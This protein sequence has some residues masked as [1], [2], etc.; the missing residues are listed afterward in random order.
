MHVIADRLL[1]MTLPASIPPQQRP[2]LP[3]ARTATIALPPP[4]AQPLR[5]VRRVP[6]DG[7]TMVAGQR[8]RVGR[9]YAGQTGTIAIFRVVLVTPSW[10]QGPAHHGMRRTRLGR[11]ADGS[12]SRVPRPSQ[13]PQSVSSAAPKSLHGEHRLGSAG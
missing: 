5:A 6:A 3:A 12:R 7:M 8:L 2:K 13:Q 1:V 11:G 9:A 4:P 10:S